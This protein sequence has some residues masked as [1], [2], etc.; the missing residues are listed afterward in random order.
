MSMSYQRADTALTAAIIGATTPYLWLHT[1]SP[2]EDGTDNVAQLS[3]SDVVRKLMSFGAIAN[4]ASNTERTTVT[5][6]EIAWTGAQIDAAQA[7]T[8][9]SIWSAITAGNLEFLDT[10]T[11]GKTTGSDGVTIAIGDVE[12][13]ITVFVKPA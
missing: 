7:I 8:H 12:C 4:H 11:T 3:A 13:A 5:D 6:A 10:V 2:G 9:F 1:G